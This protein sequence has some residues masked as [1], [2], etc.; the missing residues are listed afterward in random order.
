LKQPHRVVAGFDL[1]NEPINP[2]FASLNDQLWPLYVRVGSAIRGVDPNHAIIV[3][4]AAWADNWS[5]L[6]E[7]F[8]ANLI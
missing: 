5:T 1:L 2:D 6:A 3:E 8:D 7:P 4:G